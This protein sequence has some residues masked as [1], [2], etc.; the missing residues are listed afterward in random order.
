MPPR[1]NGN[2]NGRPYVNNPA[3]ASHLW[4][5]EDLTPMEK[6]VALCLAEHRN[7]NTGRCA[8]GAR[9]LRKMTGIGSL[10]TVVA[11]IRG[12]K[13]KGTLVTLK[14]KGKAPT[15]YVFTFDAMELFQLPG[16]DER[17]KKLALQAGQIADQ[18]QGEQI[19]QAREQG[20]HYLQDCL[21]RLEAE[22]QDAGAQEGQ[23][24]LPDAVALAQHL[25]ERIQAWKPDWKPPTASALKNWETAIDRMIRLDNRT[26]ERIHQVIDFATGDS[27]WQPNI[28]SAGKLREKFDT[29]EGQLRRPKRSSTYDSL[30]ER[31]KREQQLLAEVYAEAC[32]E[33][34]EALKA[35]EQVNPFSGT[36]LDR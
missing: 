11:A 16:I 33:E 26:P 1:R 34:E 9:R 21:D 5:Q 23:A 25:M 31:R 7:K 20:K 4:C 22:D 24:T 28:L 8:V 30:Q 19:L 17:D 35:G 36:D 32:E 27:F 29:L 6:F 14:G 13:D 15:R 18:Q 10:Q 12:L 2:A 3:L